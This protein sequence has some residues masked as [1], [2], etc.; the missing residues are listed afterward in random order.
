MNIVHSW[1]VP[2]KVY[3][4]TSTNKS[5]SCLW[6]WNFE[7][8][9]PSAFMICWEFSFWHHNWKLNICHCCRRRDS[10]YSIWWKYCHLGQSNTSSDTFPVQPGRQLLAQ[11]PTTTTPLEILAQPTLAQQILAQPTTTTTTPLELMLK[12]NKVKTKQQK[13]NYFRRY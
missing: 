12:L 6:S 4:E 3:S 2:K 9:Y 7:S 1:F 5:F 8:F 10:G 13:V 11:P